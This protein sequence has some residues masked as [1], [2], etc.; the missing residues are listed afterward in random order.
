MV[1]LKVKANDNGRMVFASIE[2]E[3][4]NAIPFVEQVHLMLD[5][6][7]TMGGKPAEGKLVRFVTEGVEGK[8]GVV[9]IKASSK[10]EPLRYEEETPIWILVSDV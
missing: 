2:D 3:S 8:P 4:G 5:I 7:S 1:T 9:R 10:G 6:Q